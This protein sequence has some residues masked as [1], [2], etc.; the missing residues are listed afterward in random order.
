MK[1]LYSAA[2]PFARKVWAAAHELGLDKRLE[3]VPVAVAPNAPNAEVAR[4]N[5]LMK[6]PTLL[7]DDGQ[8]LF[9]SR[10]IVEYLDALQGAPKLLPAA[11]A[12]RWRALRDHAQADGIMEAAILLRYETFLRPAEKRWDTWIDG[13]QLKI[14]QALDAFER[15]ASWRRGGADLVQL[16]LG[17]A[18]GYLEFRAIS[19]DIR[20]N[21]PNLTA[22]Y[23]DFSARPSMQATAPK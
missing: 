6:V 19:G 23:K 2:S 17:C 4:Q 15:D 8:A 21:R 9:D 1:L 12:A 13:Q 3:I 14:A 16:A 22:W 5:P 11:G 7:T 10:V 20:A 18:F